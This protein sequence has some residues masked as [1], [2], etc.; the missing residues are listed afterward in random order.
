MAARSTDVV[1]RIG[2]DEFGVL[3]IRCDERAAHS[4]KARLRGAMADDRFPALER[5][6]VSLGHASLHDSTSA[7]KA[8]ERADMAMLAGKRTRRRS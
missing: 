4:F 1:A 5:I 7:E 6:G 2:G 8:L 3:L